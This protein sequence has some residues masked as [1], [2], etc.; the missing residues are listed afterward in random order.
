MREYSAILLAGVLLATSCGRTPSLL[1]QVVAAG[2]TAAL[3][4]NC[5]MILAEHQKTQ[6]ESWAAGDTNLPATIT[7]LRPQIVQAARYDGFPIVDIQL[8]GGFTHRGLMVIL[9]NTP[10]DYLPRKSSWRVTK[11][12]DAIFE[13]RE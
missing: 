5:E 9:T 4:R 8:S 13:Y 2:G 6:R 12:S 7:A 10:P 11:I 1:D 3:R